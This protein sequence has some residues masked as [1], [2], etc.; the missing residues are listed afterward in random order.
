M[1]ETPG[2]RDFPG[3]KPQAAAISGIGKIGVGASANYVKEQDVSVDDE[4]L[5]EFGSFA[6]E[7]ER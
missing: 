1:T 5:L 7:R 6:T 2:R 3:G 4:K